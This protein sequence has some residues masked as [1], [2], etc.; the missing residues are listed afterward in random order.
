MPSLPRLFRSLRRGLSVVAAAA[1]LL[2]ATTVF[3]QSDKD[4][5]K[6]DPAAAKEPKNYSLPWIATLL[7]A[8]AIVAPVVMATQRKWEMPFDDEEE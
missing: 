5:E 3:A 2:A 1:V 7:G 8:A 6:K 4:A